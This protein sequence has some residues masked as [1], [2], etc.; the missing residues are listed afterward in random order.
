MARNAELDSRE[1]ELEEREKLLDE[2]EKS[3]QAVYSEKIAE[4][5]KLRKTFENGIA[6]LDKRIAEIENAKLRDDQIAKN[7]ALKNRF[8]GAALGGLYSGACRQNDDENNFSK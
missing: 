1:S 3:L 4:A 5:V 2:R 8:T 6:E 7:T